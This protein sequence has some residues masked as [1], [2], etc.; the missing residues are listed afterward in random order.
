MAKQMLY[1]GTRYN[2]QLSK[3]YVHA[4]GKLSKR[5]A[6]KKRDAIYGTMHVQGFET[7]AEYEATLAAYK[8]QGLRIYRYD[9]Q[10]D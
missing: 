10:E 2:P 7:V 8:E 1:I 6:D 9:L 3:P 4:Y 5:A